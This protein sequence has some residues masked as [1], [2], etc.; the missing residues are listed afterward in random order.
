MN[1]LIKLILIIICVSLTTGC[2][3]KKTI[4]SLPDL[5]TPPIK[6]ATADGFYHLVK[7]GETLWSISRIYSVDM[8][9]LA[10]FNEISNTCRIETGQRIFVP[11]TLRATK[12]IKQ[13]LSQVTSFVWPYK[14][15][16]ASCF[17]QI[18]K[19]V[20]NQGIDIIAKPGASISAAEAGNVIF[21]CANLRGYG[22]AIIIEHS[23]NF[24]TIYANNEK[25]LVKTGA[26]VKQGQTIAYAGSS[27]RTSRCIV[28]FE[29]RINN[30]A[31]NP[32]LYLP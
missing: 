32:L 26:Y 8:E 21:T 30:K 28:H 12:K 22:K 27:G 29:L 16:L 1:K 13:P 17:N 20:N 2:A 15:E 6:K 23:D 11:E 25:N 3:A 10:E 31:Q 4:C 19:N 5:K 24:S 9:R 7:K 18:K 14:G